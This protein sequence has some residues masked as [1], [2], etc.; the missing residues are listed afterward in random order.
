VKQIADEATEPFALARGGLEVVA[1]LGR[2]EL[3][4]TQQQQFEIP[5][6]RRQRRAQVVRHIGQELAPL[7]RPAF[8]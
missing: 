1:F 2:F 7:L 8:E 3:A 5:L 4:V 6:H